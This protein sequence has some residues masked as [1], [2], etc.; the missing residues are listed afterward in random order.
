MNEWYLSLKY[1]TDSL[2]E[3]QFCNSPYQN[4]AVGKCI[5]SE[6]IIQEFETIQHLLKKIFQ[7]SSNKRE[8]P[9]LDKGHP[10]IN[11]NWEY[12]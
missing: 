1:K 5:I 10:Q 2:S 8:L 4:N 12:T 11:N 6:V 9:Y 7:Q 3:N